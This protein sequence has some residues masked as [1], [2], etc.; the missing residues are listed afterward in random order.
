[1]RRQKSWVV[2]RIR[3]R[4]APL[5][6]HDRRCHTRRC[7]ADWRSPGRGRRAR[8]RSQ[9]PRN[10]ANRRCRARLRHAQRQRG[11][12]VYHRQPIHH[13]PQSERIT[14]L[15]LAQRLPTISSLRHWP[16]AGALMSYGANVSD[17]L[18]RSAE[19]IDKILRGAKPADIPFEQVTK[20]ELVINLKTAR[21]LGLTVPRTLLV[22]A[23]EVIE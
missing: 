8:H 20:F 10:P 4:S 19:M 21:T 23:D 22:A 9:R 15:A 18:R 6:N 5:G 12:A 3:P 2:A 7:A 16:F 17:V 13:R 11:G 1:S 14:S